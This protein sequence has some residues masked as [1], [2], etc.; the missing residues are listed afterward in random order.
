MDKKVLINASI[1]YIIAHID[2]HITVT[3]VANH[4]S[5]STYYFCHLFKEVTGESVYSFIKRVRIEQS[6]IDLKLKRNRQVSEI[7]LDYGYSSSNYS[8]VF[9]KLYEQ[10]P[11]NFRKSMQSD[12]IM[13]P[14]FPE[15]KEHL[16]PYEE[17]QNKIHLTELNDF[18]VVS[19]RILEN[20]THL[21]QEWAAFIS[22]NTYYNENAMMIEKFFSDPSVSI[23]DHSICDLCITV[24][25]ELNIMNPMVIKGGKYVIFPFQGKIEDIF[26]TLQGLFTIWLS[27]SPYQM[28]EKYGLNIYRNIDWQTNFVHMDICIPIK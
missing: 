27:Q 10:T 18:F 3:E 2:E 11:T 7:G 23:E 22:E 14:F 5:Y 20:Y 8:S 17:Y 24:D 15:K 16:S 13:N 1:D 19:K 25:R 28:R 6:A 21:K 9:K 12:R 26:S 4:L